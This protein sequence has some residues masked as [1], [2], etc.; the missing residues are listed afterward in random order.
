MK[1]KLLKKIRKQFQIVYNPEDDTYLVKDKKRRVKKY[2]ATSTYTDKP[3]IWY[4]HAL[5]YIQVDAKRYAF[6]LMLSNL[7]FGYVLNEHVRNVKVKEKIKEEKL[8]Y[9]KFELCYKSRM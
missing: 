3:L 9:K 8:L 2:N 4:E 5:S 7:G 1:T 6:Y